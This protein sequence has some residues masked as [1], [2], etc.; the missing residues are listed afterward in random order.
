LLELQAVRPQLAEL[1]A[2]RQRLTD[3]ED[4]AAI[5]DQ[6]G[7]LDE[8][9]VIRQ[10]LGKLDEVNHQLRKLRKTAKRTRAWLIVMGFVYAV[11]LT[12][13]LMLVVAGVLITRGI[14]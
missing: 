7:E 2:I 14:I 11:L 3:L 13:G 1:R 9:R 8:L 10:G 6:L 5:R 4:L 12:L